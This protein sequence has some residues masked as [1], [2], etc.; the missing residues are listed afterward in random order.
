MS[1]LSI[2]QGSN[3]VW[4]NNRESAYKIFVGW[5]NLVMDLQIEAVLGVFQRELQ[6][7]ESIEVGLFFGLLP[8]SFR[9][10]EEEYRFA[11]LRCSLLWL[12]CRPWTLHNLHNQYHCCRLCSTPYRLWPAPY[13]SLHWDHHRPPRRRHPNLQIIITYLH[14]SRR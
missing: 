13:H 14:S 6:D 1:I 7:Q 10:E 9:I 12:F 2:N 4:N 8:V 5:P 3:Y 11:M